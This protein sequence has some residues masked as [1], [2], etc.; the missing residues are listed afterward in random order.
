[1]VVHL[2]P[3]K[4]SMTKVMLRIP[5][6]IFWT[7]LSGQLRC[8]KRSSKWW[9]I[10]VWTNNHWLFQNCLQSI[11]S[12]TLKH[13][14][15]TRLHMNSFW[16]YV[17]PTFHFRLTKSS[18]LSSFIKTLFQVLIYENDVDYLFAKLGYHLLDFLCSALLYKIP[19]K[20]LP[21]ILSILRSTFHSILK[22]MFPIWAWTNQSDSVVA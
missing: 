13:P 15:A 20:S 12:I 11:R 10:Y 7:V 16:S 2:L 18:K 14:V 21:N 8:T 5:V 22:I 4:C 19:Q 3:I 6:S 17:L 9:I 1:M